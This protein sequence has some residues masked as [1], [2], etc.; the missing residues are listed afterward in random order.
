MLTF[1][2]SE[3]GFVRREILKTFLEKDLE[4]E[5]LLTSRLVD[6][7]DTAEDGLIQA[8]LLPDYLRSLEVYEQI[9]YISCDY[10][11]YSDLV[12]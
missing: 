6:M 7:L 11:R 12:K 5:N 10:K 8:N 9:N 2:Q 1:R 4:C 3:F